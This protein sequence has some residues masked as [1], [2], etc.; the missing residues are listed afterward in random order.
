VEN[1]P[2]RIFG[3][4]AEGEMSLISGQIATDQMVELMIQAYY[5]G[6]KHLAK[7]LS[8]SKE[9]IRPVPKQAIM[10]MLHNASIMSPE[11]MP[12]EKEVESWIES[13][14]NSN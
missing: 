10:D 8:M 13:L 12:Y 2:T 1:D 9:P 6:Q 4:I 14:P 7:K 11:K 5:A 3:Q